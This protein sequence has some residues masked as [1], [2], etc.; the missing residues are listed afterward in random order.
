MTH[1]SPKVPEHEHLCVF[2]PLHRHLLRSLLELIRQHQDARLPPLL[3]STHRC[4]HGLQA[5]LHG[6]PQELQ[7]AYWAATRD[8]G[9]L[10]LNA[11]QR[12]H[13][14]KRLRPVGSRQPR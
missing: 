6:L 1:H 14:W 4:N 11:V 7:D 13:L 10:H 5:L 2:A 3:K 12:Q 9:G 8:N